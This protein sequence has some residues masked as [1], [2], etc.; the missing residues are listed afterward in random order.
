MFKK[1]SLFQFLIGNFD[2]DI[3]QR[4]SKTLCIHPKK[5]ELPRMQITSNMFYAPSQ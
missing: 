2:T 3:H 4:P 5:E 1:K